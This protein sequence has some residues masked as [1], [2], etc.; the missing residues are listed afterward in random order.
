MNNIV[1]IGWTNTRLFLR[2][3]GSWVWLF[4]M[5]LTF[6]GFMGFAVRAPSGPAEARP[7]VLI[8]N[9]DEGF[10]GR[11]FLRE[12]GEQ[13]LRVLSPEAAADDA[14]RGIV[15]PPDFTARVL[16]HKQ[17]SLEFFDSGGDT[18]D[19]EDFLVGARLLRAVIA[20]N[21]HLAEHAV[22]HPGEPPTEAGL[23]ALLESP[24]SV[25]VH[26]THAGR[27]PRPVGF[28]FSLPGN[29]VMYLFLNTLIF[30]GAAVAEQRRSGVLRRMAIHATTRA[31]L[32]YGTIFGLMLL[33]AVQV[34]FL[35]AV[36]Q[37]VLGVDI[38]HSLPGIVLTLIL[39]SW[40]AASL[41]VLIG[42]LVTGEEKVVGIC[43]AIAL[44]AAA[45]AGCW[46]P[47][48]FAPAFL[49]HA[50]LAVPTGWA[51]RALHQLITFGAGISQITTSLG[52]LAAFGIAA[53]FAALRFFRI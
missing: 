42:F 38:A 24:P 49:Q 1:L 2:D 15:I 9:R 36:G 13:G 6:V 30:G 41:G 29:L 17:A 12:L 5:P 53:N 52:A 33:A 35:L 10:L 43:L 28:A 18:P 22:A 3:K 16:A 14:P 44:P 40:V 23:A 21:G 8:D 47:L 7:A 34:A 48:E 46:W 27:R 4:L 20:L 45:L 26:A 50:A 25:S 51:L 32:L 31:E 37:F 11:I 39:F 19:K